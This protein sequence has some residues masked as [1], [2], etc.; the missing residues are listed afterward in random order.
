MKDELDRLSR[1]TMPQALKYRAE[2]HGERLALRE[3]DF[4]V[5]RRTS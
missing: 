5:W 1:M 2:T 3:K 4:G